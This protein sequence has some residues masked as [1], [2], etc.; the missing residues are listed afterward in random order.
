MNAEIYSAKE[1]LKR[2]WKINENID[3]LYEQIARIRSMAERITPTLSSVN[4]SGNGN[5]SRVE[6][7]AIRL[8][9][10]EKLL[11]KSIDSLYEEYTFARNII[12]KLTNPSERTILEM[13]YLEHPH[14]TWE[15]IMRKM[16]LSKAQSFRLHSNALLHYAE[17]MKG[18]QHD[19]RN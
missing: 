6:N 9:E 8:I 3:S 12:E 4:I 2:L 18:E 10:I 11:D 5:N 7:A 1:R 16:Y 13:R 17:L 15:F 14:R 19:G